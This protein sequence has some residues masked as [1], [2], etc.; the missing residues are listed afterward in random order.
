MR[1]DLPKFSLARVR[2]DAATRWIPLLV[3]TPLLVFLD[4]PL[5]IDDTLFVKAADQILRDPARPLNAIVDWYGNGPRY[6]WVIAKNPPGL[7]YWLAAAERLGG[8]REIVWHLS[9]LPFAVAAAIAGVQLARRFA[10]ASP[11]ATA[12]WLASPAFMVSASTLMPDVPALALSLWGTVLYLDGVDGNRAGRRNLGAFVAGLAVAVKYTAVVS[13]AALVLYSLLHRRGRDV[14]RPVVDLW[15]ATVPLLAWTALGLATYGHVH[16]VDS[17]TVVGGPLVARAGWFSERGIALATFV[18]GAGV[19]PIVFLV[20]ASRERA[21]RALFVVSVLVGVVAGIGANVIWPRRPG[22]VPFAVGVLAAVGA[23]ALFT[24]AREAW[25][26]EESNDRRDTVFLVGWMA[27]HT[28]FAWFWSWTIAARFILPVFPPLALLLAR[29]LRR[30][31]GPDARQQ[32]DRLLAATTLLTAGVAFIV[33]HADALPGEIHRAI[34]P[35][36]AEQ[37]AAAGQQAHFVGGWGFYYYA[38]RAGMRRLD[39]RAPASRAGDLIVEPYYTANN[40]LPK[41]LASRLQLVTDIAGPAP[42]LG[43]HTMNS[44]VGAGFY[45]SI[46]GPLPFAVGDGPAEGVRV[47]RQIE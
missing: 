6:L 39:Q 14:I 3:L 45:S 40:D 27:L 26:D 47:W 4:R 29:A 36:V 24:A 44:W 8:A 16:F 21:G 42:P 20:A 37:A 17:L 9:L 32:T 23:C 1:K 25:R 35:A 10:G 12:V 41:P 33:L 5:A 22:Y 28:L 2:L 7:S 31:L 13:I 43:V 18:A 46:F 30:H 38:E 34:L 19:F 11:W 15:P